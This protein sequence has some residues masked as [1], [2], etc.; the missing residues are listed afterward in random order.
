MNRSDNYRG[1][2]QDRGGYDYGAKRKRQAMDEDGDGGMRSL[3]YALFYLGDRKKASLRRSIS[4]R[5]A[6]FIPVL[7]TPSFYYC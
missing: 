2:P 1:K 5:Q 6:H 3:C 4:D 7:D